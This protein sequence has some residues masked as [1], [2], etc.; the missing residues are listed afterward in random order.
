MNGCLH[1]PL[2]FPVQSVAQ[3][4]PVWFW[5]GLETVHYAPIN[6][7]L[8]REDE[9]FFMHSN[10]LGGALTRCGPGLAR[11]HGDLVTFLAAVI[12]SLFSAARL[13]ALPE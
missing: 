3:N 1:S 8:G 10:L 2:C 4:Q 9:S 12:V 7:M 11:A 5:C 6:L 13:Q